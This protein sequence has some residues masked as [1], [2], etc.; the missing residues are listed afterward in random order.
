MSG[1]THMIF[2]GESRTSWIAITLGV[3]QGSVLGSSLFIL[4]TSDIPI[5]FPKHSATGLIFLTTFRHMWKDDEV[6]LPLNFFSSAKLTDFHKNSIC[7]CPQ[8]D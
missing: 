4:Y 7:V 8:T 3:P 1:R 6:L 5:P 2:A